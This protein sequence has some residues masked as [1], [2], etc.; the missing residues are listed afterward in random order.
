MGERGF[1]LSSTK[2]DA[3]CSITHIL[4]MLIIMGDTDLTIVDVIVTTI[5]DL[6]TIITTTMIAMII[7]IG[8]TH[9]I[10]TTI[11]NILEASVMLASS[12]KENF[13]DGQFRNK[14]YRIAES[15]TQ[16]FIWR[17]AIR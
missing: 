3:K 11:V 13:Y 5:I 6:V 17:E 12:K 16:D 2:G 4:V 7:P 8:T 1:A 15:T 14:T 9:A 10:T